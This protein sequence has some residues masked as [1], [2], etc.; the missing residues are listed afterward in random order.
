MKRWQPYYFGADDTTFIRVRILRRAQ[1]PAE[2]ILWKALR[3]RKLEGYKFRRQHPIGP[4]IADFYCDAEALVVEVDGD[5]HDVPEVR[6]RDKAR[7]MFIESTG[8]K[9]IR[10]RNEEVF[11]NLNKVLNEIG[12]ELLSLKA[13][14]K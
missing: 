2:S 7:S 8:I 11:V 1:T 6:E 14:R 4:F 9:I 12:K 13:Q 10:F 5:V 3:N